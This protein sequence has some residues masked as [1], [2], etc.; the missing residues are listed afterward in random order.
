M[1]RARL[2]KTE[3]FLISKFEEGIL[4]REHIINEFTNL[5]NEVE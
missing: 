1:D 2:H 4:T 5:M 3:M